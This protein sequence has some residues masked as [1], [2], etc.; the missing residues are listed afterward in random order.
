[1]SHWEV[2]R[3]FM[4]GVFIAACALAGYIAGGIVYLG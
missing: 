1:M 2:A 4:A 3:C